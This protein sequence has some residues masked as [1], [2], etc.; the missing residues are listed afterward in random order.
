MGSRY[1][2]LRLGVSQ[3]DAP[4]GPIVPRQV[5]DIIEVGDEMAR[6]F[7]S[8]PDP[9]IEPLAEDKPRRRRKREE[10]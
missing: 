5:G 7:M 8:D 1:R 10:D 3:R 4:G 9:F 6:F 2:V